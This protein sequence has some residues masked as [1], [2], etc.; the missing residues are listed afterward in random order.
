MPD[1]DATVSLKNAFDRVP[2]ERLLDIVRVM[3]RDERLVRLIASI[4]NRSCWRNK[5][6]KANVGLPQGGPLSPILFN[7]Y[8]DWFLDRVLKTKYPGIMFI[9]W[10]DDILLICG[11][12]EQLR[13]H[14]AIIEE[15]LNDAGLAVNRE[16]TYR[17]D[18]TADL[19]AGELIEFLGYMVGLD[20]DGRMQLTLGKDA[21]GRLLAQLQM[22]VAGQHPNVNWDGYRGFLSNQILFI[23]GSWLEAY[24][25]A[26]EPNDWPGVRRDIKSLFLG[27]RP[28][29]FDLV[30]SDALPANCPNTADLNDLHDRARGHWQSRFGAP[31]PPIM[32]RLVGLPQRDAHANNT[33][34][35][36]VPH[37]IADGA[38]LVPAP[39]AF[40]EPYGDRKPD[41]RA[42][43]W[44]VKFAPLHQPDGGT[45]LAGGA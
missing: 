13:E 10:A 40:I 19:G 21:Y 28:P 9:R 25:G 45:R 35:Q 5:Q 34:R 38:D 6:G 32:D 41:W 14:R 15:L 26:I 24:A 2:H 4:V 36:M 20:N 16:K 30:G 22:D 42:V 31:L 29:I 18:A 37:H 23:I 17:P 8:L 11:S 43:E 33:I 3:V 7:L 1:F 27:S 39:L 44:R 12:L